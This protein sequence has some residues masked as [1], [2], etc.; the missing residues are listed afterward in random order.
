M[1]KNVD[2]IYKSS[3]PVRFAQPSTT[4]YGRSINSP[5]ILQVLSCLGHAASCVLVDIF[6]R[7]NPQPSLNSAHDVHLSMCLLEAL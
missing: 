7:L 4:Q 1:E 5:F 6:L 3:F 2:D